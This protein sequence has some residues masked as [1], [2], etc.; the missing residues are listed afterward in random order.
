VDERQLPPAAQARPGQ[1]RQAGTWTS[2]LTVGEF[3]GLRSIGFEPVGQV[4]G[5]TVHN[6]GWWYGTPADA[7]PHGSVTVEHERG[8][9]DR[10]RG[11]DGHPTRVVVRL[12]ERTLSLA[13]G[14]RPVAEI[15]HEVR[16]V[17]LSRDQVPLDVW[18]E[19]LARG[20]VAQADADARAAAALRRLVVGGT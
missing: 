14:G 8:L 16:G 18:V 1:A 17:V 3:A 15:H 5:S 20:L 4:M 6:L 19:T 2:S 12:G 10:L 13:G 7:L 11:R 9:G